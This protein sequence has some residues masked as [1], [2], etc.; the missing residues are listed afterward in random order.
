M[1]VEKKYNEGDRSIRTIVD[2]AISLKNQGKSE[3]A[4]GVLSE[5]IERYPESSLLFTLLGKIYVENGDYDRA[6]N[7]LKKAHDLDRFNYQAVENLIVCAEK[8]GLQRV[9]DH[10]SK[11]AYYL[12]PDGRRLSDSLPGLD[13]LHRIVKEERD[14]IE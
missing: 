13:E 3:E 14:L 9:A 12:F 4:I 10:Y 7:F 6:I 1:D 2:Y 5:G 11:I 8:L